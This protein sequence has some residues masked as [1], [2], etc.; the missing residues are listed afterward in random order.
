MYDLERFLKA[1]ESNY[2]C[3]L[4]E[5]RLGRKR[6]HWIWYVFPQLKGLGVS[7]R[8]HFYGLDGIEE[9]KAYYAHPILRQRLIEITESLFVLETNDIEMVLGA[10]DALKVNSCMTLFVEIAGEDSV[11]QRVLDKYYQGAKDSL[12]LQLLCPKEL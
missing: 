11:F 9:A 2:E 8:S 12:T 3:A 1:Q 5:I 4:N 10:I 7:N 6:T